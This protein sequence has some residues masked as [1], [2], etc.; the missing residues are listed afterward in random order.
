MIE[1]ISVTPPLKEIKFKH[2]A[3]WCKEG[4]YWEGTTP[5][6]QKSLVEFKRNGERC[7]KLVDNVNEL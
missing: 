3:P 2:K 5:A 1:I 4:E 7:W 6:I